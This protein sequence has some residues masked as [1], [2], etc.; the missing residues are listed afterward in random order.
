MFGEKLRNHRL[1]EER[2]KAAVDSSFLFVG[3]EG[4]A[5]GL[6]LFFPF[7][8]SVFMFMLFL[9]GAVNVLFSALQASSCVLIEFTL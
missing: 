8:G 5:V 1:K 6:L 7:E 3:S 4:P 9:L 2:P